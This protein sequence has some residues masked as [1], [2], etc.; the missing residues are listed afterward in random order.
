MVYYCIFIQ[1]LGSGTFGIVRKLSYEG[2][3]AAL[4]EFKRS[5]EN[6]E[7]IEREI[8]MLY[9][10]KHKHIVQLYDTAIVGDMIYMLMEYVDGGS[11]Y[12]VLHGEPKIPVS[13][14]DG[15]RWMYQAAEV[16]LYIYSLILSLMLTDYNLTNIYYI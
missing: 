7:I 8:Q 2:K 15:L 6:R 5:T 1:I 9:I 14:N 16:S 13:F 4:K 3:Y 10:V 12:R 11:L